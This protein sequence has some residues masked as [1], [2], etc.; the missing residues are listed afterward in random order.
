MLLVFEKVEMVEGVARK[1]T[2]K[3]KYGL[4]FLLRLCGIFRLFDVAI[5][6]LTRFDQE[7]MEVLTTLNPK[8]ENKN[9][10]CLKF[11]FVGR[12]ISECCTEH[13]ESLK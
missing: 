12:W 13:V 1:V 4:F 6:L 3:F 5:E 7:K 11:G 10:N 9:L 8:A 2:N